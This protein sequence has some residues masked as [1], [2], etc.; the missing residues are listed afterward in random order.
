MKMAATPNHR[1]GAVFNN[2]K[3]IGLLDGEAKLHFREID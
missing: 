2:K 1:I 3:S